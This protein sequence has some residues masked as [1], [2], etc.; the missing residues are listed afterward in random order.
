MLNRT[1][2][3]RLFPSVIEQKPGRD[4]YAKIFTL[5]IVI[6]IYVLVF[7]TLMNKSA[8]TVSEALNSASLSSEMVTFFMIQMILMCIDR[9]LSNVQSKEL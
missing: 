7:W 9:Y 2:F 3:E 8:S 1:Y 6:L 5:Q 4:M